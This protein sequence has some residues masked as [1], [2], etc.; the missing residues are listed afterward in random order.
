MDAAKICQAECK[1]CGG[2][3]AH[4]NIYVHSM[5]SKGNGRAQT[6][7]TPMLLCLTC[8]TRR[9]PDATQ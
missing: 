5:P 6:T 1:T 8:M 9:A 2:M 3:Q 4:V 7:I